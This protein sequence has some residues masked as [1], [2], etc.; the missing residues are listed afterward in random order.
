MLLKHSRRD[1]VHRTS[2]HFALPALQSCHSPAGRRPLLISR[3]SGN[4]GDGGATCKVPLQGHLGNVVLIVGGDLCWCGSVISHISRIKQRGKN[5][6]HKIYTKKI[7]SIKNKQQKNIYQN[8]TAKVSDTFC[9]FFI[10]YYFRF[11][12]KIISRL[13]TFFPFVRLLKK[14]K[15]S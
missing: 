13:T 5:L 14:K 8:F 4:R 9:Y 3:L 7:N 1:F 12:F 2:Q 10:C 11:N 6:K 15:R